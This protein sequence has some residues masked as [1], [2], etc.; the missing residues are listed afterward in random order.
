MAVPAQKLSVTDDIAKAGLRIFKSWGIEPTV[1]PRRG[2]SG[3]MGFF[4][5]MLDIKLLGATG[6]GYASGHSAAN[7]YLVIEGDGKVG[8]LQELEQSFVDLLYSYANY[9]HEF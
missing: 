5:Q 4:T 1:W 8:G 9:P 3:P 7:E 6:I 2:A